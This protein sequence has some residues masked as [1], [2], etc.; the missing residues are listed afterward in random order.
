MSL[1]PVQ[2]SHRESVVGVWLN[3]GTSMLALR[4]PRPE[5]E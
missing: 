1:F 5:A 3:V 2:R 4:K